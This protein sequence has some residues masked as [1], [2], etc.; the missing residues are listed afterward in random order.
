MSIPNG[1]PDALI[2]LRENEYVR[3]RDLTGEQ[4]AFLLARGKLNTGKTR[5]KRE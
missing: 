3:L 4:R 1:N 5:K 2:E